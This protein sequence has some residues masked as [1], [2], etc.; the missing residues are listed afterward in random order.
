MKNKKLLLIALLSVCVFSG[1]FAQFRFQNDVNIGMTSKTTNY[2]D[3]DT[4]TVHFNTSKVYSTWKIKQTT[5]Q[6]TLLL[7]KCTTARGIQC[8]VYSDATTTTSMQSSSFKGAAYNG[9]GNPVHVYSLDSLFHLMTRSSA[10]PTP[11]N[12]NALDSLTQP[13][14]CIFPMGAEKVFG[15]YPGKYKHVEYGFYLG[16]S[17]KTVTDDITFNIGTYNAGTTGKTAKYEL[18][19]YAS[20]STISTFS[21]IG[22]TTNDGTNLVTRV[23]DFYTTGDP[24]QT[25]NLSTITGR[26]PDFFTNKNIYIFLK[27]LGTS[28]SSDVVNG[29][30]NPSLNLVPQSYDPIIFFDNIN[31]MYSSPYF[32]VPTNTNTNTVYVNYNNGAPAVKATDTALGNPGTAIPVTTN[33]STPVTFNLRSFSRV[34]TFTVIEGLSHNSVMTVDAA[35]AFKANDGTGNYNVPVTAVRTDN[36]TTLLWTLTVAAPTSGA[37][38]DDMTFTFNVNRPADGS[39]SFR[40]ET[41]N[42]SA[43][44]YYDFAITASTP[45]DVN[46]VIKN[47]IGI[48]SQNSSIYVINATENVTITNVAGQRVKTVS[49]ADASGG[50]QVP[51]GIYLVK[52]GSTV[53]KVVVK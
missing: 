11:L 28:N 24:T 43:R 38:N 37:I 9:N 40:L 14:H 51:S 46:G 45:T 18:T 6:D 52:T 26:T 10:S 3:K 4:L 17:G 25:V 8:W 34:G 16:M 32:T 13:A 21:N 5:T 53:Q 31:V 2:L 49:A 1:A 41:S 36:A 23:T 30:P 39:S 12:G 20:T 27:T 19:I 50:I 42:G 35:T 15:V 22:S 48:S 29:L 33:V 44:F 7:Q 47:P